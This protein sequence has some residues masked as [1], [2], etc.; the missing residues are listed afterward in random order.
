MIPS[1]IAI[2]LLALTLAWY[3]LMGT[4][5][6]KLFAK[7][8]KTEFTVTAGN[9]PALTLIGAAAAVCSV[10]TLNLIVPVR[11]VALLFIP[12]T[13]AAVFYCRNNAREVVGAFLKNRTMLI[14]SF[15]TAFITLLP[16]VRYGEALSLHFGNNDIAF[17]LSRLER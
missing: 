9:A 3:T 15:I 17:Y 13:V 2:F 1:I 4:T 16:F 7:A 5:V 8:A 11:A 10:Q 14:V 12:V 6:R